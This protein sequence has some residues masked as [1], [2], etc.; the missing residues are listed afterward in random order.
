VSRPSS[1]QL[2]EQSFQTRQQLRGQLQ[3]QQRR[4]LSEQMLAA[5]YQSSEAQGAS[6]LVSAPLISIAIDKWFEDLSYYERT[7]EEMSVTTLDDTFKEELAAIENWFRVLSDPERTACIFALLKG[8]SPL[9]IKFFTTVLTQ[10]AATTAAKDPL[11][12]SVLRS[13]TGATKLILNPLNSDTL[14]M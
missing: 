14:P 4:P 7:L 13:P 12:H 1:V 10:M 8:I 11:S 9:Q 2:G 3:Q 6:W 5:N